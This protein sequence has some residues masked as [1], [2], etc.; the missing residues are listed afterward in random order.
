MD[1]DFPLPGGSGPFADGEAAG[2]TQITFTE[3][4]REGQDQDSDAV[5]EIRL[6]DEAKE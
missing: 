2:A 5:A 4:W 6:E 1:A 3:G